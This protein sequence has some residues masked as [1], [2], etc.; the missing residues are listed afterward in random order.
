MTLAG[1]PLSL[2]GGAFAAGG[3]MLVALYVLKLRRRRVEVPFAALWR[4]VLEDKE[5]TALWRKLR[6]L[7]SLALMLLLLLLI[8]GAIGD[9]R[10]AASQRG[11]TLVLLVDTS[12][13]MQALDGDGGGT[14]LDEAKTLL[15]RLV[16]GLGSEDQA[17]VVALDARPQPATGLT[18][19]ERQLLAAVEAL[20]P[21]DAPADLER[22][23]RLSADALRG[24]SRPMLVLLSDGAL[25]ENV[26]GRV[27][28]SAPADGKNAAGPGAIDL[29]GVDV[30]YQPVGHGS[31]N[32]GLTAFAVRRYRANQTAYEVLVEAQ[33]F[34]EVPHAAVLTLLQDG[35]IVEREKI[36]LE[37]HQRLQRLYPNLAGEG[38]RLEARLEREEGGRLDLLP[39]DDRAYALLPP[40]KKLKVLL[41]TNGNLFLEGALL[42]DENLQVEKIAPAAYSAQKAAAYDAVVLD[43]F[44]PAEP[45]PRDTLYLDPRGAASPFKVAGEL[46]SPIVTEVADH[47]LSRWVTLKDLNITRASRF[48]LEKGDVAVASSLKDALIV[49]R[50]RDGKKQAA[51]GFDLRKSDLPLRVAFP[52]LVVN[53]LDWFEGDASALVGS[54]PTGQTWRIPAPPGSSELVL[55]TPEGRTARAPVRDGRATFFGKQAGVYELLSTATRAPT[56]VGGA[57]GAVSDP[58]QLLA[59]NLASAAESRI[60]PRRELTLDGRKLAAPEPGRL[61]VRRALWPYLLVLALALAL[62]EWWT[63]NRRVT[64]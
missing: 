8:V 50:E 2:V 21:S 52:V 56:K 10:L 20:R 18:T 29:A 23:L 51:I 34:A 44:V 12:A 43:G 53:A 37:P 54:F 27:R 32:V 33:S 49:A 28:L 64:V 16:R 35:E 61:G 5:S 57:G 31:D 41:C 30:R 59:A 47:P 14:R 15:R 48:V 62:G 42:L 3:A 25:D 7:I 39:V 22:A 45:P 13:S 19:D 26:L 38:T 63:Y 1:A 58:P 24:Q 4:K 6:R 11:R 17:M 55:R 60:A 46:P 9:P 40:R 36:A